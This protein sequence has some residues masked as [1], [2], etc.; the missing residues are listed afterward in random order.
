MRIFIGY[1]KG[2]IKRAKGYYLPSSVPTHDREAV[3]HEGIASCG[4]QPF[5]HATRFSLGSGVCTGALLLKR[6][7]ICAQ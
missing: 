6:R 7:S 2:S 3:R 4:R 5:R 1:Y